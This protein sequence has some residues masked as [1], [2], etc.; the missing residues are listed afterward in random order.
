MFSKKPLQGMSCASCDKDIMSMYANRSDFY[1][2]NKLPLRDPQ[3][4]ITRVGQGFSK[5]LSTVRTDVLEKMRNKGKVMNQTTIMEDDDIDNDDEVS[6]RRI[7]KSSLSKS[8]GL[9][10]ERG[11]RIVTTQEN[12]NMGTPRNAHSQLK[13]STME[14]RNIATAGKLRSKKSLSYQQNLPLI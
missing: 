6:E 4:R 11:D 3:E 13:I 12:S 1:P 2:W 14:E 10:T 7:L 9:L 5:M 8:N